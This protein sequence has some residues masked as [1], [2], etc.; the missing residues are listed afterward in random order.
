METKIKQ[1]IFIGDTVTYDLYLEKRPN[2]GHLYINGTRSKVLAKG[3]Q[4][5]II[6]PEL[7]GYFDE[8]CK[9]FN[10]DTDIDIEDGS[11]LPISIRENG[12]YVF[13]IDV[14]G[15]TFTMNTEIG[16]KDIRD[17][18]KTIENVFRTKIIPLLQQV[19]LYG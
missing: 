9:F 14:I 11:Y 16:L 8:I 10:N 3:S 7:L 15:T 17:I 18:S 5:Q 2:E 1:P 13:I 4:Y 19:G 6:E 12:K